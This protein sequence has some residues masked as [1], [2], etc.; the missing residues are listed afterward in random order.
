MTG[1][2]S[3]G[4]RNH[5]TSTRSPDHESSRQR[6]PIGDGLSPCSL[7][8]CLLAGCQPDGAGSIAVDRE[9]PAVRSFKTF[10]DVKRPRSAKDAR[11]PASAKKPG[12][13]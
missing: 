3:S 2:P 1:P 11:K 7:G 8:R 5:S 4:R 9:D 12:R 13:L 6:Q 10:E